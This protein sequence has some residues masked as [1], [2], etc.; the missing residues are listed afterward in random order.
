M[1]IPELPSGVSFVLRYGVA[2]L[3]GVFAM[4]LWHDS[5]ISNIETK[6]AKREAAQA[7]ATTAAVIT[8]AK[9]AGENSENYLNQIKSKDAE[10]AS[11]RSRLDDGAVQLRLCSVERQ[12]AGIQA[13]NSSAATDAA[14]ANLARYQ[15]DAIHLVERGKEVDAWVE[16]CHDWVNR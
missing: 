9:D 4:W 12:T 6:E 14:R 2:V 3:A 16:S 13:H 5:A 7:N 1:K 10:I 11:L 8:D 15:Q